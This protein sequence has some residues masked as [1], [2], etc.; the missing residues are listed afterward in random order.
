MSLTKI[1]SAY[2][3][4]NQLITVS[5]T[6]DELPDS[7]N[8]LTKWNCPCGVTSGSFLWESGTIKPCE[9]LFKQFKTEV[10]AHAFIEKNL[11]TSRK[12]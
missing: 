2:Y 6:K 10:A 9:L 12:N 7:F 5:V 8:V 3:N 11:M 1:G 4:L